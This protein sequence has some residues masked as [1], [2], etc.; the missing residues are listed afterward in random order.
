MQVCN[1]LHSDPADIAAMSGA[2]R[3]ISIGLTKELDQRG[4]CALFAHQAWCLYV[5]VCNALHANP[6][7]IASMSG[8][9]RWIGIG[10]TKEL[11]KI[12]EDAVHSLPIAIANT[13][14]KPY[15]NSTLQHLQDLSAAIDHR[16][17][18]S[19]T[20]YSRDKPQVGDMCTPHVATPCTPL[21]DP[22]CN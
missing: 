9:L 13:E 6:A 1:A 5:Q 20:T 15:Y 10:L 17:M 22:D 3:W 2:L 18:P 8:A 14:V 16:G 21:S 12:R 11:D 7:D 19:V 4:C